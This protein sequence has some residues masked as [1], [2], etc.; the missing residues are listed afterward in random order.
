MT[1]LKNIAPKIFI[2]A[3]IL[4]DF[5]L[6]RK[7]YEEAKAIIQ[8]VID[9]K[10]KSFITPSIV[11]I[12]SHWATKAYGPG[13]TKELLLA[14]LS[15]VTVIDCNHQITIIALHSKIDDIEDA[16]QYYTAIQHKLDSFIS[17]DK[18][19]RQAAITS[20]PVYDMTEFLATVN[21]DNH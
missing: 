13:K 9:R 21:S 5:F 12:V 2:D 8:L 1:S 20:L 18:K 17:R 15:D 10:V 4:L 19:L 11:H 16:L 7:H 14:L 6:K 3:N